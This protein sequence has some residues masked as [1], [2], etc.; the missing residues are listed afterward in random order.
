MGITTVGKEIQMEHMSWEECTTV[1]KEIQMV[2]MWLV[3]ILELVEN[4]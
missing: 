4:E 1:G 2:L 3:G